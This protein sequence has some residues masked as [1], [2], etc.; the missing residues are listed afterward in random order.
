LAPASAGDQTA[1]AHEQ[2]E[3]LAAAREEM[4]SKLPPHVDVPTGFLMA[5]QGSTEVFNCSFM[6]SKAARGLI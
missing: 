5:Q 2:E 1:P 3:A 4:Y 6:E